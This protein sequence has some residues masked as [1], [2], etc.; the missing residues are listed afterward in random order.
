MELVLTVADFT[1]PIRTGTGGGVVTHAGLILEPYICRCLAVW[2]GITIRSMDYSAD[3]LEILTV[4]R[5]MAG[6]AGEL[7]VF[8]SGDPPTVW[9]LAVVGSSIN[10]VVQKIGSLRSRNG[11]HQKHCYSTTGRQQSRQL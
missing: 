1:N 5:L 8:A 3:I 10:T 11:K 9:P 2:P 4:V 6:I 7:A